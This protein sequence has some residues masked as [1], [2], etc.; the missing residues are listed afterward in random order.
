MAPVYTPDPRASLY[1]H[2]LGREPRRE[3]RGR[4]SLEEWRTSQGLNSALPPHQDEAWWEFSTTPRVQLDTPEHR[5]LSR[6]TGPAGNFLVPVDVEAQIISAARAESAI[7]RLAREFTTT[8]GSTLNLP[9]APTHGTAVW[10]AENAATTASDETFGE[11]ALAAPKATTKVIVSE[12]LAQDVQVEFDAYLAQEIGQRFGP[13]EGAAFAVGSGSGQP[14]GLV[15]NVTSVT[16]ATG[17]ATA[18]KLADIVSL[19]NALPAAYRPRAVF[20]LHPD[21]FSGL[22]SLT[23]TAGGLVLPSLQSDRP[24]LLG[25]PVE[26]D[27]GLAAPAASAKSAIFADFKRAYTVRRVAGISVQRLE[28]LHS[29]NGQLGFRGRER[30]DGRVALADAARALAHSAT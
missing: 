8:S 23:D 24:T 3:Y 30:V 2:K 20:V 11:A 26:L 13:L 17:S 10:T 1:A 5:A 27:A 9:T 6:A 12:E 25:R 19:Y 15:P 14:Q 28:E 18:F 22:A 29:D 21:A 4:S 16:A 7:A